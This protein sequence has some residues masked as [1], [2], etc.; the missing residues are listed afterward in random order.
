M[1]DLAPKSISYFIKCPDPFVQGKSM[2]DEGL[3]LEQYELR[4]DKSRKLHLCCDVHRE[5]SECALIEHMSYLV[6]SQSISR[7]D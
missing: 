1:Y 6:F 4:E 3:S 2:H 7:E 5:I